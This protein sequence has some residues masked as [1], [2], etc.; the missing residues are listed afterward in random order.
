MIR[1]LLIALF[2]FVCTSAL[3]QAQDYELIW[4][5]DFDGDQV[6]LTKWQF[7]TGDGCNLGICG[8]GNEELQWYKQDNSTVADGILTI[9]AKEETVGSYNYTSSRLRTKGIG[10][11]TYGRFEI[12]AK[13]PSTAGMWPAFWMLPT[14]EDYGG[15]AA[16]GEIDILEFSGRRP[17]E[18]SGALHFG[19]SWPN[20]QS[21]SKWYLLPSGSPSNDFHVYALEWEAGQ[22]KWFFDDIVFWTTTTWNSAGQAFPA[23]FDKRFHMLLNFAVGGRF[24]GNPDATTILPQE[25][26]VDYI[27]VYQKAIDTSSED[28]PGQ[29]QGKFLNY[30]NPFQNQTTIEYSL[31]KSSRVTLELKDLFGRS[32]RTVVDE[33]KSQGRYQSI[34]DS[35]EL[36]NGTYL[37]EMT[38]DESRF[39]DLIQIAK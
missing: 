22:M 5:D 30:P 37:L 10:D 32:L 36:P 3:T 8:W 29:R 15:W 16:S 39:G 26:Q 13:M 21:S 18:T 34:L 12:R 31:E 9:T 17:N 23:P 38:T 25:L 7:Q 24:P 20:N 35:S 2:L 6:D 4:S 28:S 19:G 1:R 11:W 14:D 33:E 27:K